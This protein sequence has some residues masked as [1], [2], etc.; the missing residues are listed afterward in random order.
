MSSGF[1]TINFLEEARTIYM[2]RA[3]G[4]RA[5][6]YMVTRLKKLRVQVDRFGSNTR[7]VGETSVAVSKRM[8]CSQ[9]GEMHH[10]Q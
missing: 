8:H 3:S 1:H 5:R 6:V 9:D 7:G 2:A 4:V 10:S